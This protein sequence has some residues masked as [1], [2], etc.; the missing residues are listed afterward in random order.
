MISSLLKRFINGA[1]EEPFFQK[2]DF[3]AFRRKLRE[4]RFLEKLYD[5][6]APPLNFAHGVGKFSFMEQERSFR[7]CVHHQ[8]VG[9]ELLKIPNDFLALRMFID[10]AEKIEITLRIADN[11]GVIAQLKQTDVAMI[12]LNS[13]LLQ[14]RAVLGAELIIIARSFRQLG[15]ILVI[16][17]QRVAT[18]RAQAVG[19]ARH[20]HLQHPEIDAQLQFVAAIEA[21][22]FPD[23][24]HARF[25]RPVFQN[26]VEIQTHGI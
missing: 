7:P 21:G 1:T 18:V 26:G 23:F 25:V 15:A 14:L 10:K 8:H 16:A 20:L 13:L 3:A 5:G 4:I 9:P 11:T 17:K 19:T 2:R 12:I 22:H 6:V 24:D